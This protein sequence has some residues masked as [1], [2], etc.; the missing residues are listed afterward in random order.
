MTSI[1]HL[2][3]YNLR[4]VLKETG[5]RADVLRA[6]ERR[7]ELPKPQRSAGGHRLYSDYDI[8]T[9]KW[10]H[11]RQSEGLSI[12]RAAD[13]WKELITSGQ[14]PL[15]RPSTPSTIENR[16]ISLVEG[17]LEGLRS[18]W[19]KACLN[20]DAFKAD[21]IVNQA[22]AQASVESVCFEILQNGLQEIGNLWHQDTA[23]VQQEHFATALALR[24]LETLISAAPQP[25]RSKT[26]LVGCPASEWH[27]F[28]V[29]L[30]TLMLRRR[31]LNVI[32]LGANIPL[33][34]L[35]QTA[36]GIRPDLI[37]LAAQQ[38][39]TVAALRSAAVLLKH[40]GIPLGYG[41]LIFNRITELRGHIPA[42][43]LG[44]AL[45]GAVERI[46]QLIAVPMPVLEG[47]K[48]DESWLEIAATYRARCPFIEARLIVLLKKVGL[49]DEYM[50]AVNAYFAQELS[51][52]LELG[53]PGL[54]ETDFDWLKK[55]L[56]DRKIP[57][58][59]LVPYLQA[60]QQAVEMEMGA[61]G[62]RITEWI[63][64]YLARTSNT[65]NSMME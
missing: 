21:D 44:E 3:I 58:D 59:S 62:S 13:L 40:S 28:P 52:A 26:I 39:S 5:L 25:V 14:D 47:M 37:V 17:R 46:E 4:V 64:S 54:I 55:L 43:F 16:V 35:D 33:E 41:G 1:S 38:L 10:L 24:R 48:V 53:N 19:V 36:A 18:Q 30:L 42:V 23:T 7:Y 27:T 2:P 8:A 6:W 12:S 63:S 29:V 31:G 60:Y 56:A 34:H 22:F 65:I 51:A 32:N 15:D 49:P 61:A 9:V 45:A 57:V 11:A 20:F 50:A